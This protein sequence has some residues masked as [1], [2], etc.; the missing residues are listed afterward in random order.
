MKQKLFLLLFLILLI[1]VLAGLNAAS[2]VQKEKVPDN[3][4][5]PNRSTYNVGATG[6]SALYALLS[7]TGRKV[8]RWQEPTAALNTEKKNKPSV[9]VVIGAARRE[10]TDGECDSLLRWVSEGGRLVM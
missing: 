5:S 10:F 4:W 2:Y 1:V 9:F 7:E 6:T 3:E 8:V